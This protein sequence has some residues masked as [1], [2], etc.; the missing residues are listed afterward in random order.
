MAKLYTEETIHIDNKEQLAKLKPLYNRQQNASFVCTECGKLKTQKLVFINE[1][2]LCRCCNTSLN[3]FKKLGV[4]NV[5][6]LE[7]VKTKCKQTKKE[8]YGNENYN[9]MTKCKETCEKMYGGIGFA[10]KELMKKSKETNKLRHGSEN[11]NNP[12]KN[13]ETCLINWRT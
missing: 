10:S 9:N 8:K 3:I 4:R 7:S 6:Q 5:F 12:D 13:K 1:N 11:Y 2:L